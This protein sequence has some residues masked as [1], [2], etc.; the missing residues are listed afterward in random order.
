MYIPLGPLEELS[1]PLT[2]KWFKSHVC[3]TLRMED[4]NHF[5]GLYTQA[6]MILLDLVDLSNLSYRQETLLRCI[7]GTTIGT[8]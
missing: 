2:S 4:I 8:H 3:N 6:N 5:G 1:Y 7:T